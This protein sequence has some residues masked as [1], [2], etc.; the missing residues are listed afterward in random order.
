MSYYRYFIYNL[1]TIFCI[2][3]LP[4]GEYWNEKTYMRKRFFLSS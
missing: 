2:I 4:F 3:Q 1:G